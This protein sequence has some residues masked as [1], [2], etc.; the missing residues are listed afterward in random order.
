M[1][2]DIIIHQ[3]NQ[4]RAATGNGIQEAVF[5]ISF[6][7]STPA[8]VCMSI[9][10]GRRKDFSI[11]V[12]RRRARWPISNLRSSKGAKS[13]QA[14]SLKCE[15]QCCS[16]GLV[17]LLLLH[18]PPSLSLSHSLPFTFLLLYL[19]FVRALHIH[20]HKLRECTRTC[21][22]GVLIHTKDS[23]GVSARR[24]PITLN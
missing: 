22:R 17:S 12:L 13:I 23:R 1:T 7:L 19:S 15:P 10:S 24:G 9:N 4:E 6:Y 20:I 14:E 5:L 11:V 2:I 8:Y 3:I 18:P 21:A 16:S